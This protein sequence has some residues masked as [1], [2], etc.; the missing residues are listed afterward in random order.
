MVYGSLHVI[1]FD[2]MQYSFR[3]LGEFVLLRLSS[4]SGS[5]V[6]TLQGEMGRL[7][8]SGGTPTQVPVLLRLAAY[9]QGIGKT[10]WVYSGLGSA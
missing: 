9:Y 2:G 5:N 4:E 3:A 10:K 7:Q 6:F 8:Q 1:T